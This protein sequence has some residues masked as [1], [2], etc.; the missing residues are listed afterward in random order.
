MLRA[1]RTGKNQKI[2]HVLFEDVKFIK[3]DVD[4]KKMARAMLN[5]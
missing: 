5:T 3:N 2:V 4:Q 1:N